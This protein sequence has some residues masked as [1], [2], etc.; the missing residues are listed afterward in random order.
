MNLTKEKYAMS[1]IKIDSYRDVLEKGHDVEVIYYRQFGSYEGDWIALAKNKE[2]YFIYK[3]YYGS[4]SGCDSLE[5]WCGYEG[6]SLA[7]IKKFAKNYKPFIEIPK[8]TA[9]N[10]V[11]KGT[12]KTV[13][14]KNQRDHS[15][16]EFSWK[17]LERDFSFVIKLEENIDIAAEDIM[18]VKD[19]EL[20]QRALK[21]YGYEKFAKELGAE[22]V[23][24]DK[25]G[26][27]I[28]VGDITF[29]KVKDASTPREYLLRVPSEMKRA[30]QA[31]AWTFNMP[32]EQYNPI[33]E[34]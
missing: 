33:K 22:I 28:K 17:D 18:L 27:L 26:K 21:K 13:L 4:C 25:F 20:Q 32:E 7:E 12:L 11:E 15:Y 23:H 24:E 34:T 30:K 14:P 2:F 6:Q 10:L 3:D 1:L 5:A 9:I 31:V 8:D 19:L 29:V 16:D